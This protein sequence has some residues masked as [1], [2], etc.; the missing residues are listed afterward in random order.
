MRDPN[1]RLEPIVEFSDLK[2]STGLLTMW[3]V[4]EQVRFIVYYVE[5]NSFYISALGQDKKQ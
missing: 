4:V 5:T 2:T 1:D 3:T